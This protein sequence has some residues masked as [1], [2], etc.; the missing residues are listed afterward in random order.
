MVK[1]LS[2]M[3]KEYLPLGVTCKYPRLR[4]FGFAELTSFGCNPG[5]G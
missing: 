3:D 2:R 1:M 4:G 5:V